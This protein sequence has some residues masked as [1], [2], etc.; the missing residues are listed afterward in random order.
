MTTTENRCDECDGRYGCAAC[1]TERTNNRC[2]DLPHT[3]DGPCEVTIRMRGDDATMPAYRDGWIARIS[4]EPQWLYYDAEGR[5]TRAPESEIMR[6]E[7]N[8]HDYA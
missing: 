4:G 3:H 1:L 5:T 8:P 6:D 7:V 2:H